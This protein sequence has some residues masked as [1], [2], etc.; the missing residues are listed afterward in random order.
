MSDI[1]NQLHCIKLHSHD[2]WMRYAYA[3][4]NGLECI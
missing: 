4:H 2:N 3:D 1:D